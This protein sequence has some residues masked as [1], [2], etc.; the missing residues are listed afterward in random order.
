MARTRGGDG[1][2][3]RKGGGGTKGRSGRP[4]QVY[5]FTEGEVTEPEYVAAAVPSAVL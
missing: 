5:V 4:R 3:R 2:N 1:I